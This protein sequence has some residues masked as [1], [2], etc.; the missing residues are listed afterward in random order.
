[1]TVG[2]ARLALSEAQVANSGVVHL[3]VNAALKASK[4]TLAHAKQVAEAQWPNLI[5]TCHANQRFN[6]ESPS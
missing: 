1:M 5:V 4:H 3:R 6:N 2:R